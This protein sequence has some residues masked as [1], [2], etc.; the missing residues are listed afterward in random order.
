[1]VS[2]DLHQREV[3]LLAHAPRK[4][5]NDVHRLLAELPEDCFTTLAMGS[6]SLQADDM[7]HA[8]TCL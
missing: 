6:M 3:T 4:P 8:S 1:M 7:V 5:C 2:Q